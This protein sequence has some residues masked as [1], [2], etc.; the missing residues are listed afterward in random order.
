MLLK[1]RV[2]MLSLFLPYDTTLSVCCSALVA[3]RAQNDVTSIDS[4]QLAGAE[5]AG[6]N[7]EAGCRQTGQPRRI[8]IFLETVSAVSFHIQ[9]L[10]IEVSMFNM[11]RADTYAH[12]GVLHFCRCSSTYILYPTTELLHTSFLLTTVLWKLWSN[13][14]FSAI[15][16]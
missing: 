1:S 14:S 8:H 2:C 9:N 3:A 4:L 10:H 15:L 13:V 11:R 12:H 5:R 7:S 6:A 16:L